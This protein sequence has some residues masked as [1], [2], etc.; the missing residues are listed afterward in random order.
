MNL[1]DFEVWGLP[2]LQLGVSVSLMGERVSECCSSFMRTDT[3]LLP[4]AGLLGTAACTAANVSLH[5]WITLG[6]F[7]VCLFVCLFF[8]LRVQCTKLSL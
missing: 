6:G 3:D 8:H 2:A 7:F 5:G 1:S 4:V